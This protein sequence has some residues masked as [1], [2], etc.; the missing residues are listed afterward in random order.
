MKTIDFHEIKAAVSCLCIEANLRLPNDVRACLARVQYEETKELPRMIME[1]IMANQSAAAELSL[2]LC[3]DTGSA[4]IFV[5]LGQDVHISGG[6]LMDAIQAGVRDGYERGY[7][8]KSIV[9]ALLRENTKDNTPA[10]IHLDLVEG[11][12][13]SITVLPK[14]GGAENKSSMIMLKPSQGVDG[15]KAF[16][17]DVVQKAGPNPCPPIIVGVGVGGN[18][19]TA[20]FLA[21]KA[22]MREISSDNPLP[23]LQALEQELFQAIN[24]LGV[25]V[26]GFGGEHTA[27]AVFIEE[28]PCHFA[29]LPVAVNLNCHVARHMSITL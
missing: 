16:V 6:L 21:K 19:E 4:V 7:L 23:H 18:F 26:Q 8:R 5:S 28:M 22:L 14:G 17:L 25:G 20:P 13:L 2:P 1:Q 3:Q 11:E 29:S 9:T 12:S 15:M 24:E 10:I 27:L